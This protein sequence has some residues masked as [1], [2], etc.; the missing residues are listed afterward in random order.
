MPAGLSATAD[1]S[2]D[3][4]GASGH[5]PS[6]V[7]ASATTRRRCGARSRTGTPVFSS[8]AD[9]L[10]NSRARFGASTTRWRFGDFFETVGE[11]EEVTAAS[12]FRRAAADIAS[13][14]MAGPVWMKVGV[15]T[16]IGDS[17]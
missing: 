9:S 1:E 12:C 13:A 17:D 7:V 10:A 4:A 2:A 6:G 15:V 5:Q 14:G 11:E 16:T 8:R 3:T